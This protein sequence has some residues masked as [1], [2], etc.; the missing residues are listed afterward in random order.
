MTRAMW[1]MWLR[2][3][4]PAR[5]LA[6]V[7]ALAGGGAGCIG[8]H[9]Q[10]QDPTSDLDQ[11]T[12]DLVTGIGNARAAKNLPPPTWVDELRPPAARAAVGVARG[13]LSLKPAARQAALGA[14][15]EIGR[16][17]WS[18][19]TDCQDLSQVQYPPMVLQGRTVLLGASVVPLPN[20]KSVVVLL[21]AEP[22]ASAIRADQ[23]GGGAGGTNPS[24]EAYAHPT[25][26]SGACGQSWPVPAAARL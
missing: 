6:V 4:A 21:I 24:L 1:T 25:V 19:V 20:G 23:M 3:A 15:T 9:Y 13:D 7:L 14:V 16:H 22:G 26:A 8:G 12:R 2:R 10:P 11:A 17:V 18:F 5:L